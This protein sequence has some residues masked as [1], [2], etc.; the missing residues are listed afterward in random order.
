MVEFLDEDRPE[1]REAFGDYFIAEEL[2]SGSDGNVLI[3]AEVFFKIIIAN[4]FQQLLIFLKTL[5]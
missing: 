5:I 4:L 3:V 1:L 2:L